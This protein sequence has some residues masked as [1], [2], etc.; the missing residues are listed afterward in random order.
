[1]GYA[2]AMGTPGN[3]VILGGIANGKTHLAAGIAHRIL[4]NNSRW[5]MFVS[6]PNL[7]DH[8]RAAFAPDVQHPYTAVFDAVCSVPL[9]ILDDFSLEGATAWAREKL[10]QIINRRYMSGR[11]VVVVLNGKVPERLLYKIDANAVERIVL[12]GIP[13]YSPLGGR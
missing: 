13:P 7:L 4:Q 9:L 6:V 12:D 8:L 3:L 11:S 1:M 10:F 2:D 5:V